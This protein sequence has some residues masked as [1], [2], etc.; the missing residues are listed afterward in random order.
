MTI[1]ARIGV[2]HIME[3]NFAM[4]RVVLGRVPPIAFATL[5]SLVL[6]NEKQLAILFT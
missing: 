5:M 4:L 2:I 6:F 1:T 3:S